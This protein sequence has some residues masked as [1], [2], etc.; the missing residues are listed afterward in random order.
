MW[1]CVEVLARREDVDLNVTV[2]VILHT[3]MYL[4]KIA[5]RYSYGHIGRDVCARTRLIDQ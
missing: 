5:H 3:Y 4:T 2:N 1:T